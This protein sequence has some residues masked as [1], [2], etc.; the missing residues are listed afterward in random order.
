M[1]LRLLPRPFEGS[2][3]ETHPPVRLCPGRLPHTPETLG[4]FCQMNL[5]Q[6]DGPKGQVHLDGLP[7]APLYVSQVSDLVTDQRL[8][9]HSN[10]VLAICV[11]D[12]GADNAA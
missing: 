4:H 8:P 6:H 1:T 3:H 7:G 10:T 11:S 12:M 2:R 5:L 9:E